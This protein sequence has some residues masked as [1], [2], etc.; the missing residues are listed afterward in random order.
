MKVRDAGQRRDFSRAGYTPQA[1]E[2]IEAG[3]V[4]AIAIARSARLRKHFINGWSYPLPDL[5]EF[6]D[7]FIFRAI[8]AASGLGTLTPAEAM[9]LRPA[10]DGNGLFNG[11]GLYRLSLPGPIPV[12]AFWSLTMYASQGDGRFFLT[13]NPLNR[14]AIGDRT[15]GLVRSPDGALDIWISRSGPGGARTANR[16]PAP[17]Q[18]RFALTLRAYLPRQELLNGIYRLPPIVPM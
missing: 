17:Q 1:A 16:L 11:D 6:A 2:A 10:G 9:Y 3:V 18:G 4:E 13:A 5:G 7:H 14:H 12:D 8:V 15:E